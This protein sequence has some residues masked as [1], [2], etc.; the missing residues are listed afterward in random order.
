MIASHFQS[1]TPWSPATRGDYD[2]INGAEVFTS[3]GL[4]IGTIEEILHPKDGMTPE[5]GGRYIHVAPDLLDKL[6][7]GIKKVYLPESAIAGTTPDGVV[8]NLSKA[9]LIKQSWD[10]PVELETEQRSW[11]DR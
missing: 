7:G 11:T 1:L 3:D 9:D 4:Y 5:A 8:L 10:P 2:A 6:F